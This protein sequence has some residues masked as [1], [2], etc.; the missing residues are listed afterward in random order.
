MKFKLLLLTLLFTLNSLAGNLT[1]PDLPEPVSNNAVA[2]V[3][4]EAGQHI[5]SFMGLGVGKTYK[6]VHDKVWMLTLGD[7]QWQQMPAV[8][9]SLSLKGRLASVAIGVKGY[10]YVFGGYTVAEDHTEISSPDNFR[11]DPKTQSFT[12]IAPMPVPTDDAVALSYQDKYIYLISGWHND[13]NVNLVQ[14]YDIDANTWQ[15]ASPFLGQ[16]VFGHAGGIVDNKILLC[17]G[18]IVKAQAQKRRTFLPEP[19]CYTGTI[20]SEQPSKIDWRAIPHPTGVARYRMAARG[21]KPKNSVIFVGGSDNPYNYDGIGY[22]T[23]PSEPSNK[24]WLYNLEEQTWSFKTAERAS[25]DHRGLL[26]L[27][28]KEIAL[29]LGGMAENQTVTDTVNTVKL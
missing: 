27:P 13:G 23:K 29:T 6:D 24:I 10:A 7:T 26:I 3:S 1:L 22:D 16:P 25:M 11:F 12:K 2:L 17:D 21:Y 5:V 8:P 9:S 18:V 20:N 19:A 14:I 28:E 15:Q 4:T